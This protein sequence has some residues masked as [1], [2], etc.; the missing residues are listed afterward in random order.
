MIALGLYLSNQKKAAERRKN[1]AAEK[2]AAG[3]GIAA[4]V[5]KEKAQ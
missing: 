1:R 3:D 4:A 2:A 5:E